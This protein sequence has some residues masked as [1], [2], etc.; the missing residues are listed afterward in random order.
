MK[1]R[2]ENRPGYKETKVGWI[3]EEWKGPPLND[4]I[5]TS[6]YGLSEKTSSDGNIPIAG[7]KHIADG[8]VTTSDCSRIQMQD[9]DAKRYYLNKGDLLFN[10]TNSLEH[11][12][13]LGIVSKNEKTVFASY[14]V[15]LLVDTK[16][17]NSQYLAYYFNLTDTRNHLRRLAT[18]GASQFNINASELKKR[19]YIPLPP[20]PE[21]EKIAE[22]L[23]CWDEGIQTL[24][25]LIEQKRLRKKGL[26]QQ[27]LI[28]KK[29]LPGFS[30]DWKEVHLGDVFKERRE[31]K[32][33]HLPL[34]A[35]TGNRGIIPAD[36]VNKKDSS[37]ADKSKYKRICPGDIGYNTMR[38]W[39][40]VS[41]VSPL[42]GIVSPAYTI[43]IPGKE[44][45]VTFIGYLF[46]T[47]PVIFRFWRYSQGLVDDTLNLKFP[48]F[49]QIKITIPSIDEQQAIAGVL[50]TADEEIQ[51]L[52]EELDALREQKK[53]LMQKL[54]TGEVRCPEFRT[55][56]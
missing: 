24:E 3:P 50:R 8:R 32:H 29:R 18:P 38:M 46:K 19:I 22:V 2:N 37:N 25:D 48:A 5:V 55:A 54:L 52:E 51:L 15:R 1:D 7:M 23:E 10:R 11:V 44:L 21:Q 42:E 40:G 4:V 41:A 13:K 53:G 35:I 9:K 56:V 27:L 49:A 17:T 20:L 12:G 39:Q 43:C 16:T 28:G 31:P 6:E 30:E 34:L 26:M 47:T 36:E 33:N 45:D 14:L